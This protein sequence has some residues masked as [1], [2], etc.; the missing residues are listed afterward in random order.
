MCTASYGCIYL[1]QENC[2][3]IAD[4]NETYLYVNAYYI[5]PCYK[6]MFVP[7]K[8]YWESCSTCKYLPVLAVVCGGVPFSLISGSAAESGVVTP[9]IDGRLVGGLFVRSDLRQFNKNF[10]SYT[11]R[12]PKI[13][14]LQCR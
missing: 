11:I 14:N 2:V 4:I 8:S 7:N 10:L 13:L 12:V 3:P 1:D 9:G 6:N 5:N